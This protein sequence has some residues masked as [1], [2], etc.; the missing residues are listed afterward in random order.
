MRRMPGMAN[1]S[2]D[3]GFDFWLS[4][5]VEPAASI[6]TDNVAST[7][8]EEIEQFSVRQEVTDGFGC[9][10]PSNY[11]SRYLISS[12]QSPGGHI[13]VTDIGFFPDPLESETRLRSLDWVAVQEFF[14]ESHCLLYYR[15][16][17]A[18]GGGSAGKGHLTS[19]EQ[20]Q[21]YLDTQCLC[22]DEVVTIDSINTASAVSLQDV[23]VV[24]HQEGKRPNML[25]MPAT[26]LA[27]I[28][29]LT[30]ADCELFTAAVSDFLLEVV[31][32][33]RQLG[34]RVM[35][36][37]ALRKA[38]PELSYLGWNITDLYYQTKRSNEE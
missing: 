15:I 22:R 6:G 13:N 23:H 5:F 12:V 11:Q 28:A 18:S 34:R 1:L 19:D 4:H 2:E 35:C 38:E 9:Y 32:L 30:A 8:K 16:L 27:K 3:E 14:P 25:D 24:H 7:E 29:V 20:L 26:A 17:S 10:H 21:E 37:E 36:N 31:W 33:E